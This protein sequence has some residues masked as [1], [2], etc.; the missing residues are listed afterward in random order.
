MFSIY[1]QEGGQS[2]S[3]NQNVEWKTIWKDDYLAWL[4]GFANAQGGKLYIGLNDDGNTVG[5]TQ[6][7]K[8][9]EDLPNKIRDALGI[10]VNINLCDDNGKDYIEI[11]VPPY[12]IAISCK[13]AYYY[14]SGST[15]QKL[16]GAELENFLLKRRGLNWENLPVPQ[17]T[18]D[19]LDNDVIETFKLKAVDKGRVDPSVLTE[20]KD[21]FIE[22]LHLK[23][24][25]FLTNAA[26]LLFTK[27]PERWI[28]GAYVKIGF[29]ETDAELIYQDEIRGSLLEI[30]DKIIDLLYFKYLKAKIS[31]SGIQRIEK[32]PYPQAALR[33]AI[34]NAV[35]HKSYGCRIPIQIS[36]YDDRLY[37]GNCGQLPETWTLENLFAKHVS[38]PFNPDIAHIMYLAGFIESWGRGVE[39]M[40][41]ACKKDGVSLPEY[42]IHPSD[43]M[44]KFTA[45]E[46]RVIF[47]G[48]RVTVNDTE[49]VTV[50]K[51]VTVN[52]AKEVTVNEEMSVYGTEG[53]TVNGTEGV[54]VNKGVTVND[55]DILEIFRNNPAATYEDI[56]TILNISRKTTSKRI[57]KLKEKGLIVRLGSDKIGE[58]KVTKG[59]IK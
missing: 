13:G 29:F 12:P 14:R 52:D 56:M 23:N 9:L 47:S 40:C 19:D 25:G 2:M 11:D 37:I 44:I 49:G 20:S 10:I 30:V 27:D 28:A 8:L 1:Q 48:N 6:G 26:A 41:E 17:L 51:W 16:T 58:W 50:N 43:I 24:K 7:K 3:E 31:Y 54:T 53:V 59:D 32:Y 57:K 45:P 36:V 33:E 42:T 55:Q 39:K 5:L 22:K 35:T 34:L 15:N 38:Q 46:D 4:C 18:L 21:I